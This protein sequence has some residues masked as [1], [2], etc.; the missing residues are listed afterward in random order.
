MYMSISYISVSEAAKKWGISVRAVNYKCTSGRIKGAQKIANIWVI[1]KDAK[2]PEDRR[3][4][5]VNR[6]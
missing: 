3:R 1:P 6:Q 4:K 5:S 2:R